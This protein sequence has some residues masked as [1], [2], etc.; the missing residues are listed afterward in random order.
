[1]KEI[2]IKHIIDTFAENN[3]EILDFFV[4]NGDDWMQIQICIPTD[5]TLSQIKH[6]SDTLKDSCGIAEISDSLLH[7]DDADVAECHLIWNI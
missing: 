7:I 6:I 1:M 4:V 2:D 3:V 5:T